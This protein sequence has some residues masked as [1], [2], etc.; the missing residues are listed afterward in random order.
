MIY[1]FGTKPIETY[2]TVT[3]LS[4]VGNLFIAEIFIRYGLAQ[5]LLKN[6]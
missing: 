1:N 5:Y 3:W 6:K 2:L 4:W